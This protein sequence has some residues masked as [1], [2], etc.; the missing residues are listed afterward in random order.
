MADE[1]AVLATKS[2]AYVTGYLNVVSPNT[3]FLIT[4][5]LPSN[6]GQGSG[7]SL[8]DGT[9][10]GAIYAAE[11][12]MRMSAVPNMLYVGQHALTGTRGVNAANPHYQDVTNA[13]NQGASI[14]TVWHEPGR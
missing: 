5:F 10:Y 2:A 11:Y 13:Y 7:T 12:M 1:N 3:K 6:D 8:T 14:D 4:E 9:L